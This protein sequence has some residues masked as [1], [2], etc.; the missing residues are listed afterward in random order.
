MNIIP[1][2]RRVEEKNGFAALG[3]DTLIAGKEVQLG[4]RPWQIVGPDC[5]QGIGS[6]RA[7]YLG[8]R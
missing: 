8:R 1:K 7:V 6:R 2:P 4:D 3:R 5:R